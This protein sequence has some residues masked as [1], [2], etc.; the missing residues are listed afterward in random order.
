[1]H[2]SRARSRRAGRLAGVIAA[3]ACTGAATAVPA[4]GAI[5]RASRADKSPVTSQSLGQREARTGQH[6]PATNHL[7]PRR[8]NIELVSKLELKGA[9]GNVLPG[10][11]AD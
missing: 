4:D 10:Q 9:F 6:E 7:P 8:E 2:M 3:I 1:M 5:P 11:I